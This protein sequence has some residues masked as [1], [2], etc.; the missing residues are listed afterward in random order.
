MKHTGDDTMQSTR[1]H[2][3]R[4]NTLDPERTDDPTCANRVNAVPKP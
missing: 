3:E 4:K 1:R 2:K